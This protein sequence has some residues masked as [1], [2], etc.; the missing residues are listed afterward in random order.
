MADPFAALRTP[1]TPVDPDPR[2]AAR[3]RERV[4]RA[5]ALPK[6]M[7]MPAVSVR[8]QP[9]RAAM[10]GAL[11][12]YLAVADARRALDW[13]VDVFGARRRGQPIVMPDG[14]IGHAEI[15]VSGAVIMLAD[16]FHEIGHTAPRPGQGTGVS[17]RLEVPDLDDLAHRAVAAGASLD[18]PPADSPHGRGATIRDPFGHRWLL[19]EPGS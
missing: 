4:E 3:L 12:P 14:R 2:F 8:T 1:V 9:I 15:E 17:L 16:E 10:I 18:Q 11:T 19:A 13:Y 6:G 7:P 5:L